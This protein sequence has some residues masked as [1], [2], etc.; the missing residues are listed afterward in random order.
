MA[1][2][3]KEMKDRTLILASPFNSGL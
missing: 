3:S 1:E 2:Q